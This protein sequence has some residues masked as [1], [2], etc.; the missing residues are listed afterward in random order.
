V[1]PDGKTL[2]TASDDGTVKQWAVATGAQVATFGGFSAPVHAVAISPDGHFLAAGSGF[3]NIVGELKIW[4]LQARRE[5][6]L[7]EGHRPGNPNHMW[8]V[9]GLAFSP[10][11][12][13]L[14]SA[15]YDGRLILWDTQTWRLRINLKGHTGWLRCVSFSHDGKRIATGSD[16]ERVILW[17]AVDPRMDQTIT[18]H[19]DVVYDVAFSRDDSTL[20]IGGR[21]GAM[22]WDLAA[23]QP[24]G[25]GHL[26]RVSAVAFSSGGERLATAGRDGLVKVWSSGDEAHSA[27]WTEHRGL[28]ESAAFSPDGRLLATASVDRTIVLWDAHT[29]MVEANLEGHQGYVRCVAFSPDGKN[30]ASASWDTTVR[31]W[32]VKQRRERARLD[33]HQS[34]VNHVAFS[35]DGM[36]LVSVA[37][38]GGAMLWDTATGELRKTFKADSPLRDAIF[39][40]DGEHLFT[41][42]AEAVLVDLPGDLVQ[43]DVASG[44][45]QKIHTESGVLSLALSPDGKMLAFGCTD[46]T[47]RLWDV[48]KESIAKVLRGHTQVVTSLA[49]CPDG[50]SLASAS[51]DQSIILWSTAAGQKLFSLRAQQLG[52][53]GLAFSPDGNTLVSTHGD[54]MGPLGKNGVVNVWQSTSRQDGLVQNGPLEEKENLRIEL[55]RRLAGYEDSLS[56]ELGERSKWLAFA[57]EVEQELIA[58]FPNEA[59]YKAGLASTLTQLAE[60]KADEQPSEVA[61]QLLEQAITNQRAAVASSPENPLYRDQLC[62]QLE[63]V[64][65]LG[66]NLARHSDSGCRPLTPTSPTQGSAASESHFSPDPKDERNHRAASAL[67]KEA[68]AIRKEL[69]EEFPSAPLF[70]S[71][72]GV[73]LALQAQLLM[74]EE[75]PE[76]AREL[77]DR[78]VNHQQAAL[79]ISPKSR[80]YLQRLRDHRVTLLDVLWHR[81]DPVSIAEAAGELVENPFC[82]KCDCYHGAS[83]L[84]GTLGL[85]EGADGMPDEQRVQV[86]QANGAQALRL[87]Q[88]SVDA[89]LED[90]AA[91][92]DDR[93]FDGLRDRSEFQKIAELIKPAG[94]RLSPTALVR[95]PEAIDGVEGWTIETRGHRGEVWAIVR[96]PGSSQVA[97]AGADGVVRIWD[98]KE[99]SL[100]KVLVGHGGPVRAIA[101]SPDGRQLVSGSDD[102]TARIWDVDQGNVVRELA[103]DA[104]AITTIDWSKDGRRLATGSSD[105]TLRLWDAANGRQIG[106]FSADKSSIYAA[107]LTP[108]GQTVAAALS[109]H[110]IRVWH[111]EEGRL[112]TTLEGHTRRIEDL[113]WSDDGKTLVSC[114]QDKTVRIWDVARKELIGT[115]EGHTSYVRDIALHGESGQLASCSSDRTIRVWD[116]ASGAETA[117]VRVDP[118][119]GVFAWTH[120]GHFLCGTSK[121]EVLLTS[122]ESE[123]PPE[124]VAPFAEPITSLVWS[125]SGG[126]IASAGHDGWV[127]IWDPANGQMEHRFQGHERRIHRIAWSPDESLLAVAPQDRPV[128]VWKTQA[129]ELAAKLEGHEKYVQSVAWSP[130]GTRLASGDQIGK[131]CIWDVEASQLVREITA[132][133]GVV[134]DLVW[135]PDGESAF[136]CGDDA[137]IHRWNTETGE[138]LNSLESSKTAVCRLVFSSDHTRFSAGSAN[139]QIRIWETETWSLEHAFSGRNGQ[140]KFVAWLPEDG[141]VISCGSEV[142]LSKP[143]NEQLLRTY[144]GVNTRLGDACV[145]PDGKYVAASGD[146]GT[147]HLW[148]VRSGRTRA[149]MIDGSDIHGLTIGPRGDHRGAKGFQ[150]HIVF[151]V[152]TEEGQETLSYADMAAK[153][154]WRN[155]P[156][157]AQPIDE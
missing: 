12:Q 150:D 80:N 47:V 68:L 27:S 37:Y 6:A 114:S 147:I 1:A 113:L 57:S 7:L 148:E 18:P 137:E 118:S 50:R 133:E 110:T 76:E 153:Y 24:R 66:S 90:Y 84:A 19:I 125:P 108:D 143:T 32:D 67:L 9:A 13:T 26:D 38:D 101:F 41:A 55:Q 98:T 132:H 53:Y 39:S 35:P 30:L 63:A 8:G 81:A 142:C 88:R 59:H 10:D 107:A 60:D 71:N 4:D 2:A 92:C 25:L 62:S 149:I 126:R 40:P 95:R 31:I 87:L 70:Q 28:V 5:L 111:S 146:D 105:R 3:R 73:N 33:A 121:G 86:G 131:V 117:S 43:W 120:E 83:Y 134:R 144:E 91:L 58:A 106:S 54:A 29:G 93:R 94:Q 46:M 103:L 79:A 20:A 155:R 64:A 156:E 139:G 51:E 72:L 104:G 135:S 17:D 96:R 124:T 85:L 36:T 128:L 82:E 52:I 122:L 119:P 21:N 109:D 22:T 48:T 100:R 42:G 78:A 14:A 56:Y 75:K 15:G 61:R 154:G 112:L 74:R 123:T 44:D 141:N 129:G 151:V 152:S 65:R 69:T 140:I 157:K 34:G 97:T 45:K 16:D 49:Y 77:L 11:G 115:L 138:I 127:R 102:K 145:S 89:G 116:L 136:S 23:G 99:L 130:D